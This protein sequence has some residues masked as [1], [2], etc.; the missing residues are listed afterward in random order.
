MGKGFMPQ[1]ALL[2]PPYCCIWICKALHTWC[3]N[4]KELWETYR[5]G[6]QAFLRRMDATFR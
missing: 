2:T 1:V 3:G 5:R 4:K 6:L